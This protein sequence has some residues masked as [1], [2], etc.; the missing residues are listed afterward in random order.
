MGY[1]KL[2]VIKQSTEGSIKVVAPN[3]LSDHQAVIPSPTTELHEVKALLCS[4]YSRIVPHFLV[5]RE[6]VNNKRRTIQTA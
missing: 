4:T 1:E 5:A 2:N 3:A 6:L